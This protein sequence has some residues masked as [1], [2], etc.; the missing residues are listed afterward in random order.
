VFEPAPGLGAPGPGQGGP[1]AASAVAVAVAVGVGDL[2]GTVGELEVRTPFAGLV[3]GFLAH[4]GERVVAGQPV[5][6]LRL[7]AG[8]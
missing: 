5:A 2:L 6:W 1:G 8:D 7:H 4:G 3:V